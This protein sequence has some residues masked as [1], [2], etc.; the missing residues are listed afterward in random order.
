MLHW[1]A[2]DTQ[3]ARTGPQQSI[4]N[5]QTHKWK[6][7]RKYV[8]LTR[9][10]SFVGTRCFTQSNAASDDV[11]AKGS[12]FLLCFFFCCTLAQRDQS[13]ERVQV[14]FRRI[15]SLT[16]SRQETGFMK[17]LFRWR[18]QSVYGNYLSRVPLLLAN[19]RKKKRKGS[20]FAEKVEN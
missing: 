19:D 7:T 18:L 2:S 5:K 9:I 4:K 17:N 10:V 3:L 6:K 8:I 15:V 11:Y 16:A 12:L 1:E 13:L 14:Y 20:Q